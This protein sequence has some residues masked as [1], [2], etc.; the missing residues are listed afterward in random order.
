VKRRLTR[1]Y[2]F[3]TIGACLAEALKFARII[4]KH[5]LASAAG[6]SCLSSLLPRI[7]F[8]GGYRAFFDIP[9]SLFAND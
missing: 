3:A 6:S 4:A 7:S 5:L 1:H 9:S 8:H 2:S